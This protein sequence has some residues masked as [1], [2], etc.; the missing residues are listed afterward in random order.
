MTLRYTALPVLVLGLQASAQMPFPDSA[1]TWVNTYYQV[2]P[3]PPP[4]QF[5]LEEVN[6][7]CASGADTVIN[8]ITYTKL[9][10]CGGGYKGAFRDDAGAVRYVPGGTTQEVLLYDFGMAVGDTATVYFEVNDQPNTTQ[11]TVNQILPHNDFPDRMVTYLNEGAQWIEGI[12]PAWGLFTEP[13]V[14]VS[15]Y[16]LYLECMSHGDTLLYPV[17]EMNGACALNVG[18]TELQPAP[19]FTAYPN[20]ARDRVQVNCGTAAGLLALFSLDGR[21]VPVQ[22][23]W[24]GATAV[25]DLSPLS[26]G[27]YVLRAGQG[28]VR[29]VHTE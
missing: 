27:T 20:P 26:A 4:A 16:L 29:L 8:A 12:G 11:V 6:S 2:V 24:S 23:G 14:N 10:H 25:L 28:T 18:A 9:E 3:F 13:Y 5:Y 22:I 15:N 21:T 1:A 17:L 19:A 7:Y